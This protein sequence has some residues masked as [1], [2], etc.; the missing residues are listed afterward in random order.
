LKPIKK[1][2]DQGSQAVKVWNLLRKSKLPEKKL[3]EIWFVTSKKDILV[4]DEL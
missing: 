2:T 3:R 4:F 1:E